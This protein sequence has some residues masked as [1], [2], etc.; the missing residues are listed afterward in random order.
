MRFCLR[1]V[2]LCVVWTR[3]ECARY[4]KEYGV[5]RSKFAF[6]RHHHTL[7]RYQYEVTDE[8]YIFTGGNSDRDYRLF[9]DAVRDLRIPCIVATNLPRL[10][11]GLATPENVRVVSATAAE[12]RQLMARSRLVVIPMRGNLLRTGGQ[13]TFLNAMC[14]RKPVILTDPEGGSDYIEDGKTG[15]LVRQGDSAAL[16][17]AITRLWNH[18]EEAKAIGDGGYDAALPLTTERCNTE[19]WNLSFDLVRSKKGQLRLNEPEMEKRRAF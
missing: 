7:K 8:G 9:F 10:L 2:D 14:M 19:I 3:V 15:F 16:R 18:S 6:V 17:D 1:E 12:F 11:K 5:S 4:S 13:Q